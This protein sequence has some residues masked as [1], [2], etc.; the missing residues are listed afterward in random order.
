MGTVDIK[1]WLVLGE[2]E[3]RFLIK[4]IA[5]HGCEGGVAGLIY[6]WETTAF[7]DEHEKEI[8]DIVQ[9]FAEDSGQTIM[10]YLAIV[11]K[12]AGS[13]DQLRCTLVWLAVET[14]AQDLDEERQAPAGEA[15]CSS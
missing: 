5:E 7:H 8:W 14:V 6:Y 15:A 10:Q 1:Q 13:L 4:D 3:E 11:A 12:D 9:R 2:K